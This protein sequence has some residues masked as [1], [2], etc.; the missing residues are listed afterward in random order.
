MKVN[1]LPVVALD[2]AEAAS[3]VKFADP[4]VRKSSVCLEVAAML[5]LVILQFASCGTEC[6]LQRDVRI[7]MRVIPMLACT[8]KRRFK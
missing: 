4:A 2:T 1:Q 7:L 6:V 5:A 3:G 8:S